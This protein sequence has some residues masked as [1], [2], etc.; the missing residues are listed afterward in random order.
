MTVL[1]QGSSLSIL[2]ANRIIESQN[3]NKKSPHDGG[4]EMKYLDKRDLSPRV[5]LGYVMGGHE[6]SLGRFETNH[7]RCSNTI[8][9]YY[10]YMII[11]RASFSEATN[12]RVKSTSKS[13]RTWKSS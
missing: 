11:F 12:L 2:E 9:Y 8:E 13:G 3:N 7:S 5:E 1:A 4:R 10:I 6:G